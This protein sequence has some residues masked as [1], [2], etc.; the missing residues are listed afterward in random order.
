MEDTDANR[1][2]YFII[3]YKMRKDLLKR[4]AA[5]YKKLMFSTSPK[6]DDY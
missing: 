3:S 1:F 4:Y 5:L 6:H 2:D